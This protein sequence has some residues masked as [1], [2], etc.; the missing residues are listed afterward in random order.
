MYVK[1]GGRCDYFATGIDTIEPEILF[2]PRLGFSCMITNKLL[3]RLH[4]GQYTQPPLYDHIYGYH[5][6]VPFPPDFTDIPP[7]GNP[8]LRSEKTRS[9]EIGLQTEL[10]HSLFATVNAY[11]KDVS[12]LVGTRFVLPTPLDSNE[13]VA[14][15]NV[16]YA[17][18]K[19]IEA[20]LELSN[21]L[22]R[23]KVSYTLSWAQGTSSYA[24]EVYRKY[25]EENF[26][27][28]FVLPAT[29]YYLDF[30]QRH[31]FFV[32]GSF[33]APWQTTVHLFAFFGTGFPYT[34]PGPEGEYERRNILRLPFQRHIDCVISRSFKMGKISLNIGLE[35]LNLL[36]TRY[37][38]APL[39]PYYP[40]SEI[41]YWDFRDHISCQD[42]N[43]HPAADLNH[44]GLISLSEHF[45]VFKKVNR[46][47][48]DWV[49]SYTAPRR[50]RLG[51]SVQY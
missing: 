7:I 21:S 29:D 16:E 5:S 1:I 28:A 13:Y 30:D 47:T 3:L 6:L 42:D 49:N 39:L 35:I 34:P 11:Y 25:Y 4:Y 20:I 9:Y 23:G 50:L 14:Y 40:T 43:Y 2:S 12:D 17:N 26:D 33:N 24:E 15:F 46:E 22:F 10:R 45:I 37:E 41:H 18:V 27:S 51:V 19:G 32:Q 48:L 44:D 38:I 36:N 8:A 31:R